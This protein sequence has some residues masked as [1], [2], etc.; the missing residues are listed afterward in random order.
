M[1]IVYFDYVQRSCSSNYTA[2]RAY[3]LSYLH[4]ITLHYITLQYI[5]LH[6]AQDAFYLS[7]YI[8][9]CL[10]RSSV[11]FCRLAL[12]QFTMSSAHSLCDLCTV[13][14][15]S[16]ISKINSLIFWLSL[17]YLHSLHVWTVA[18]SCIMFL[19]IAWTKPICKVFR[20]LPS[21]TV[22]FACSLCYVSFQ[23]PVAYLPFRIFS[24]Y[25]C[26]MCI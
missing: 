12:H 14:F 19:S 8:W 22:L 26:F 10:V 6:D 21:D 18:I 15:P 25:P 11:S 13:S 4:Y 9:L 5:T 2:Y 23:M 24:Q 7:G 1:T 17:S 16:I 20:L 3:K